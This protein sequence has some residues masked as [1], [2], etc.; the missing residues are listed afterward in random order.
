[1][2]MSIMQSIS[3]YLPGSGASDALRRADARV[4]SVHREPATD[5]PDTARYIIEALIMP[6]TP[7]AEWDLEELTMLP[8]QA[9]E[10]A[11]RG[12]PA[13]DLC[14]VIEAQ[15]MEDGHF[16]PANNSCT[17]PC[18]VRLRVKVRNNLRLFRFRYR[19]AL[20]GQIVLPVVQAEAF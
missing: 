14:M 9:A 5:G 4:F 7:E 10:L 12:E 15:V 20:F 18:R 17:G 1:M 8:P 11:K 3:R 19:D 6:A 16:Q 13:P 2:K